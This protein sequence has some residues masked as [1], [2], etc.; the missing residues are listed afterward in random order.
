MAQPGVDTTI[1]DISPALATEYLKLNPNNR[2][3]NRGRALDYAE[4]LKRGEWELNGESI[5]FDTVGNLMDGQHR[6]LAVQLSGVNMKTVVV[7]GVDRDSMATLNTGRK[8]TLGDNLRIGGVNLPTKT[9]ALLRW[10]FKIHEGPVWIR[11]SMVPTHSQALSMLGTLGGSVS[12]TMSI[13]YSRPNERL[14]G[15]MGP[16]TGLHNIVYASYGDQADSF[17][18]QLA[19]G[20]NLREGNPTYLLREKLIREKMK[21]ERVREWVRLAY[22]V[23]AWNA[24]ITRKPIRV[25]RLHKDEKFPDIVGGPDWGH[26]TR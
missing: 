18:Q 24:F 10:R 20:A 23:K 16:L 13:V 4:I 5:I 3:L 15:M 11:G 1:E 2:K 26:K 7:R 22:T 25:L 19:T 8:R 14:L 17:F 21:R 6:L 12:H 9:A